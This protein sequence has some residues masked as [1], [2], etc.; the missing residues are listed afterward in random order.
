MVSTKKNNEQFKALKDASV[1]YPNSRL[2][3][4]KG[5]VYDIVDDMDVTLLE[6]IGIK[7]KEITNGPE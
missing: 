2:V 7:E 5:K 6:N 4:E 3:F 1:V